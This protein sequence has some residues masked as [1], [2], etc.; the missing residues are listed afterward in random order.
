VRHDS[1]IDRQKPSR[2]WFSTLVVIVATV[3]SFVGFAR[4]SLGWTLV[5]STLV[6]AGLLYFLWS[7]GVRKERERRA[8]DKRI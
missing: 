5:I 3:V 6:L 1:K 7:V 4:I 8:R 2:E